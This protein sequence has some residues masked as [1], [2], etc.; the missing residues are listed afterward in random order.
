MEKRLLHGFNLGF[1]LGQGCFERGPPR[2]ARGALRKD[3]LPLQIQGLLLP[4]PYCANLV[5]RTSL[6][7]ADEFVPGAGLRLLQ[8][9]CHLF[10]HGFTFPT[11]SHI[12]IL[13]GIAGNASPGFEKSIPAILEKFLCAFGR[14]HRLALIL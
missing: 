8:C 10:L 3:V 13:R 14:S 12:F 4:F 9:I 6:I 2:G 7:F 5:G 1:D 11:T